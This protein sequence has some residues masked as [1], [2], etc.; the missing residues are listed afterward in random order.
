MLYVGYDCPYYVHGHTEAEIATDAAGKVTGIYGPWHELYT[1][2]A[3]C[4][5]DDELRNMAFTINHNSGPI[6]AGY[7]MATIAEGRLM[8]ANLRN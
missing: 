1:K 8:S 4:H 2:K 6:G 7:R 3:E 5:T